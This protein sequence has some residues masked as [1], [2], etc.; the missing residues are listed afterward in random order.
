[1]RQQAALAGEGLDLEADPVAAL[2]QL[3]RQES[4]QRHAGVVEELG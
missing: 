1:V 3:L 2:T 4:A